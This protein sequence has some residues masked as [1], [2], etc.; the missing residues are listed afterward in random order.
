MI[1]TRKKYHW[2]TPVATVYKAVKEEKPAWAS[3]IWPA[4]FRIGKKEG[5]QNFKGIYACY[6]YTSFTAW[7]KGP[8]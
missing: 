8:H 1:K 6:S 5:K 4:L 3:F 7:V 2:L